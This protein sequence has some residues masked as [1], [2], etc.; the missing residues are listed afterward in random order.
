M[1]V[2]I[3]GETVNTLFFEERDNV[4][5]LSR[6]GNIIIRYRLV[7]H[8]SS[9]IETSSTYDEQA[10]FEWNITSVPNIYPLQDWT[11]TDVT[12]RCLDLAEPLYG[13]E[14][15]RFVLDPEDAEKYANVLSPEFTMTA[16]TLREQLKVIGGYIHAEPRLVWPNVIKFVPISQQGRALVDAYNVPYTYRENSININEYCTSLRSNAANLVQSL[17][18]G[19]GT[20]SDPATGTEQSSYRSVRTETVYARIVEGNAVIA[21]QYPIY[22][23]ED[24]HVGIDDFLTP[25]SVKNFV[26]EETEYAAN[27]KDT[28]DVFPLSKAYAIYYTRGQKNIKG[29]Y[30]KAEQTPSIFVPDAFK[31][32]YSISLI[33]SNCTEEKTLAQIDNELVSHPQ[34]LIAQVTYRPIYPALL[35]HSK[36]TF[37]ANAPAFEKIYQQSENLLES[38]YFGENIKGVAARLGNVQEQRTYVLSRL[39]E[40]PRLSETAI[41]DPAGP[42]PLIRSVTLPF[43]SFII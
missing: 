7:F 38:L 30:Y 37:D 34:W 11:I 32:K 36:P 10:Y 41:T 1:S 19:V 14:K 22:S 29:M 9:V 15:P 5:S 3:N 25:V 35:S 42:P 43:S 40:I 39:G 8:P 18:Y 31:N 12:N 13:D 17:A 20:M 26:F 23:I 24:V 28:Y 21:T 6:S 4:V 16:C 27:L 33:L 2:I